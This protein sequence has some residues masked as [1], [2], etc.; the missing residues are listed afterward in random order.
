MGP[1]VI[2]ARLGED[3][4]GFDYAAEEHHSGRAVLL[5]EGCP[6]G[7]VRRVGMEVVPLEDAE[8]D[9]REWLARWSQL[10]DHWQRASRAADPA[11]LGHCALVAIEDRGEAHGTAWVGLCSTGGRTLRQVAEDG[12]GWPNRATTSASV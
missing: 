6:V 9:F 11:R 2:K 4:D 5:R 8:A 1:Y 7:L 3:L 12:P 10:L